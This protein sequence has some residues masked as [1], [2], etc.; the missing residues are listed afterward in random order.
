[1][2]DALKA[3]LDLAVNELGFEYLQAFTNKENM[4]S[5]KLLEKFGFEHLADKK[6]ENNLNNVIY[7]LRAN[8]S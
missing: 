4:S 2:S 5:R 8:K 1:M 3:I 7:G 6:D